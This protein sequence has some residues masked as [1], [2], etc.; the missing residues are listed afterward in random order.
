[1]TKGTEAVHVVEH[2]LRGF[3]VSPGAVIERKR[4]GPDAQD[5]QATYGN[6]HR[7]VPF[8]TSW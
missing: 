6:E 4:S 8:V 2:N 5:A 7:V 3:G 1:V